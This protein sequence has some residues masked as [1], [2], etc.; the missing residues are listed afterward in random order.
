VVWVVIRAATLI[1]T[2]TPTADDICARVRLGMT[3]R[4]IE[5]ATPLFQ[6][7]HLLRDDVLVIS[8]RPHYSV[9]LVCRVDIDPRTK[10]ARSKSVGPI[11]TKDW[12]TF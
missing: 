11:D 8:A 1:P 2:K 12:P 5:E 9:P 7:W 4:E 10:R 3:V 6:G